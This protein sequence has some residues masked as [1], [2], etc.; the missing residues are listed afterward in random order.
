MRN[1]IAHCYKKIST[2]PSR[3]TSSLCC[4]G[5]FC[6]APQVLLVWLEVITGDTKYGAWHRWLGG[7]KGLALTLSYA[8]MTDGRDS[9]RMHGY[10]VQKRYDLG[11]KR[12]CKQHACDD[13]RRG[14]ARSQEKKRSRGHAASLL[15]HCSRPRQEVPDARS[16]TSLPANVRV[17]SIP[18]AACGGATMPPPRRLGQAW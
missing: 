1:C 18:S 12:T 15:S 7:C 14:E 10:A 3:T 17:A 6:A 13:A 11:A 5:L 16:R 2:R 9:M 4:F 8:H